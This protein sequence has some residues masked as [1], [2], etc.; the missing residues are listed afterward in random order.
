[1]ASGAERSGKRS[2]DVIRNDATESL[3]AVPIH[4]V[5]TVTICVRAG[6]VVVV[7]GVAQCA[8]DSGVCAGQGIP[9]EAVI[10]G[11]YVRPGNRIVTGGAICHGKC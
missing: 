3:R 5:A 4:G 6:E 9:G 8:P 2:S 7:V 10:E 11:S 1:M